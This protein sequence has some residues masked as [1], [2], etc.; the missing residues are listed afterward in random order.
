MTFEA[1]SNYYE[2][3]VYDR[4]LATLGP[5]HGDDLDYLADV[6]CVALNNLPARY[7]RHQVDMAFYMSSEER[8]NMAKDIKKAVEDAIDFVRDHRNK[9]NAD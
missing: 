1:I 6:A 8:E 4:I 3:P 7:I 2:K 9:E 5:I